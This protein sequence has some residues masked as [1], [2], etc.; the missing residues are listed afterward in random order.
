MQSK[1]ARKWSKYVEG[2]G[3]EGGIQIE[4]K[5]IAIEIYLG[6]ALFSK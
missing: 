4:F 3:Q 1:V 2:M 5:T 6:V